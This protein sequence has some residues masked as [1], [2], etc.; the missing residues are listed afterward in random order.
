MLIK[1]I[2]NKFSKQSA[3]ELKYQIRKGHFRQMCG[4]SKKSH[5]ILSTVRKFLYNKY[6]LFYELSSMGFTRNGVPK[7]R[8]I[9]DTHQNFSSGIFKFFSF[10]FKNCWAWPKIDPK[11]LD[12][13]NWAKRPKF[14]SENRLNFKSFDQKLAQTVPISPAQFWAWA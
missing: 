13:E 4:L 14:L 10:L 2:L 9:W 1:R 6:H 8:V 5:N 11:N 7:E 3:K 12:S